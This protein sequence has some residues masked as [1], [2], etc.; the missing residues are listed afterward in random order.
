M[1]TSLLLIDLWILLNKL[2]GNMNQKVIV[3]I[4]GIAFKTS[5]KNGVS[6]IHFWSSDAS[7]SRL[8]HPKMADVFPGKQLRGLISPWIG[9]IHSPYLDHMTCIWVRLDSENRIWQKTIILCKWEDNQSQRDAS[10]SPSW[11]CH[12]AGS[13]ILG[14]RYLLGDAPIASLDFM[15]L[16]SWRIS[17]TCTSMDCVEE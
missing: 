9:N 14:C 12:D 4:E 7:I 13:W 2:Q 10:F 16:H 17:Y 11:F 5:S 15:Q 8:G 6:H 1:I 3:L